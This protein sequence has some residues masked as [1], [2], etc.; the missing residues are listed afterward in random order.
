M[1]ACLPSYENHQSY[2]LFIIHLT[3]GSSLNNAIPTYPAR[4][5]AAV[6]FLVFGHTPSLTTRAVGGE[7]R[8]PVFL[9]RRTITRNTVGFFDRSFAIDEVHKSK[10]GHPGTPQTLAVVRVANRQRACLVCSLRARW[11]HPI[12]ITVY[13]AV[14]ILKIQNLLYIK[15]IANGYINRNDIQRKKFCRLEKLN[16]KWDEQSR[17]DKTSH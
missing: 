13:Q 6:W 17:P 5:L 11:I 10:S 2:F 12:A 7:R 14:I 16:Y 4:W 8:T 15:G 9:Y 3:C 1:T